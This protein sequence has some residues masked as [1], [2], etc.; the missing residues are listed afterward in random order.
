MPPG[1]DLSATAGGENEN[2]CNRNAVA[3]TFRPGIEQGYTSSGDIPGIAGHQGEVMLGGGRSQQSVD[4]THLH[5][6]GARQTGKMPP[7]IRNLLID[8]VT[9]CFLSRS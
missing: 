8:A 3:V 9:T 5:A 1:V 6:S 2:H 7:T 4:H